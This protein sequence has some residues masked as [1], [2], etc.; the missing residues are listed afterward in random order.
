[1]QR[2]FVFLF[3]AAMSIVGSA[4]ADSFMSS[5]R[6]DAAVPAA[7]AT[8]PGEVTAPLAVGH[9]LTAMQWRGL[10]PKYYDLGGLLAPP[11]PSAAVAWLRARPK[12]DPCRRFV[13]A[14][15]AT[16]DAL[17]PQ[18]ARALGAVMRDAKTAHLLAGGDAGT[19]SVMALGIAITTLQREI[20]NVAEGVPLAKRPRLVGFSTKAEGLWNRVT[21][22]KIAAAGAF[23]EAV[24][25]ARAAPSEADRRALHAALRSAWHYAREYRGVCDAFEALLSADDLRWIERDL[26]VSPRS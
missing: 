16:W 22:Q 9:L 17:T 25:L 18:S 7:A 5:T 6:F 4:R 13:L 24:V 19:Q 2:T 15:K 21:V 10:D 14:Y 23:A 8:L 3:A 1:M 12:L 20:F 11:K 26:H